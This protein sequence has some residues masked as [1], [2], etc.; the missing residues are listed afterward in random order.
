MKHLTNLNVDRNRLSELPKEV[1]T[2]LYIWVIRIAIQNEAQ[3]HQ[4]NKWDENHKMVFHI[5][6]FF[7]YDSWGRGRGW[8]WSEGWGW[9]WLTWRIAGHCLHQNTDI[10]F[11]LAKKLHVQ[12]AVIFI[13]TRLFD[14]FFVHFLCI[15]YLVC[16][17][18]K[19]VIKWTPSVYQLTRK[20]CGC[21][22]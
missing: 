21:M 8:V 18:T 5:Q 1:F 2:V 3:I 19:S 16:K 17:N 20:A 12:S 7:H 6:I 10:L 22:C 15:F 4:G 14:T 11:C 13:L 9:T